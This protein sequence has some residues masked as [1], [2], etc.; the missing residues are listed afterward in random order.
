MKKI[1]FIVAAI[2]A[3][4]FAS[5]NNNKVSNN[6]TKDTTSVDSV[7]DSTAIDSIVK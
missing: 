1:L 3:M 6:N 2:A 5:C 4:S 7:I